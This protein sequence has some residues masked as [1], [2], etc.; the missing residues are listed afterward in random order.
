MA[1]SNNVRRPREH[2]EALML[3]NTKDEHGD[4]A[5][6]RF[7]VG[8]WVYMQPSSKGPHRVRQLGN[9]LHHWKGRL[10][11]LKNTKKEGLVAMV[12]H[13]YTQG[14]LYIHSQRPRFPSNCKCNLNKRL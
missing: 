12:Q 6:T 14:D 8:A 7:E 2:V 5:S 11:G 10:Q 13:V 9:M 3:H 1:S 4:W